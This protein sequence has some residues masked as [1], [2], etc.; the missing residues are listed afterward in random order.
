MYGQAAERRGA[1]KE[2]LWKGETQN[3]VAVAETRTGAVERQEGQTDA[4]GRSS[5]HRFGSLTSS[6][7]NTFLGRATHSQSHSHRTVTLPVLHST[8]FLACM[9]ARRLVSTRHT[10]ALTTMSRSISL[11]AK[12]HSRIHLPDGAR[13]HLSQHESDL[14]TLLD[15][16]TAWMKEEKG[17]DITCR[18]A[19]GWVRDKV[20]KRVSSARTQHVLLPHVSVVGLP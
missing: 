11:H 8:S 7:P 4:R 3:A 10:L 6:A 18:V 5:Q 9:L 15:E 16:C 2:R 13:V 1:A 12:T 20:N 14:C 17:M 19:G